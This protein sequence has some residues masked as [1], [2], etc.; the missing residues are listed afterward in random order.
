MGVAEIARRAGVGTGTMFRRFP[1]KDDLILAILEQRTAT[2]LGLAN[3]ALEEPDPGAAFRRF[4]YEGGELQVR[5]RG[6]FDAVATRFHTEPHLRELR[7]SV[8]DAA[9]RL[10]RGAQDAGAVR[11]DLVAQDV[12]RLMCA[13]VGA[14]GPMNAAFP[15]LWRRYLAVILDGLRPEA[16]TEL[17]QPARNMDAFNEAAQEMLSSEA[18]PR[19]TA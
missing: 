16:A 19:R 1:T 14:V 9:G 12:P 7:D 2:M 17:E 3:T 15:E 10:L 6:F 18:A 4:M 5:D 13:A 11:D 8:I